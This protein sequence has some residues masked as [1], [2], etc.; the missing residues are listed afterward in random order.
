MTVTDPP[1]DV[2]VEHDLAV[3]TR[4]GT[5]LRVN[6]F[7]PRGATPR[8]VLLCAHPYGKDKLPKRRRGKWTFSPQYRALR[9]PSPVS[10]SALTSWEA[11]DPAWWVA[12]GFAVVNAD[13]RGCGTS[14][15]TGAL[16]SR[17]EAEDIYGW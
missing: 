15:G 11:P 1:G 12:Q 16:L 10:F 3:T 6:V 7:R 8:S 14:D 2:V 4:D 5:R 9:Q 13:L 17:Q